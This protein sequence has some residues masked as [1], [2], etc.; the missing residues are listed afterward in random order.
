MREW[1]NPYNPFN[2]IKVLFWKEHLQAIAD[3]NFLPPVQVDTDPSNVCN[4]RCVWCNAQQL[5]EKDHTIMSEEHLL[6]LAD[7]Y[8]EWGV[9]STCIAGG[10]EPLTN[11]ALVPFLRRL[12]KNGIQT[13]IISN[14]T[15]LDEKIMDAV[16]DCCRWFG[17]SVDAGNKEAYNILKRP[18]DPEMFDRVMHN[19]RELCRMRDAKNSSID[20]AYK[21]LIHPENCLTILEACRR[22]KENGANDVQI[23]PVAWENVYATRDLAPLDFTK[24][25][26]EAMRQV[27]EA[28]KL[29]TEK[30]RVFAVQH[31]F[32]ENWQRT[33][34]FK[35]CRATPLLAVFS[36]DGNCYMCFQHRGKQEAF[37]C[38]HFPD[39]A[40]VATYWGS[41]AHKAKI[42]AI[43]P[44]QCPRCAHGPHNEIIEKVIMQDDMCIAFP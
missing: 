12:H 31:K 13:G 35:K 11:K 20:I 6:R 39:P 22:A 2:S 5:L 17:F 4:L 10:G 29:Q 32:A 14:G 28:M 8:A 24:R 19:M 25:Q 33:I 9:K 42:D 18:R 16:T 36:A 40:E 26:N 30:F 37:L 41:E 3:G 23:R 21:F 15:L 44:E 27:D 34:L 38:K 43:D 7:F 1:T